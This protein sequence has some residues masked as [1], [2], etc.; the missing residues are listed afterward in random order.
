[1]QAIGRFV[2][3]AAHALTAA[4]TLAVLGSSAAV[5]AQTCPAVKVSCLQPA[6]LADA[7]GARFAWGAATGKTSK[8]AWVA[9]FERGA[10]TPTWRIPLGGSGDDAVATVTLSARGELLVAG[11]TTSPTLE[12]VAGRNSGGRDGF[13]VRLDA[14]SGRLLSGMFVGGSGDE[15]LSGVTADRKGNIL[16][17]GSGKPPALGLAPDTLLVVEPNSAA[18]PGTNAFLTTL[19]SGLVRM[20]SQYLL[21]PVRAK[22]PRVWLDCAGNVVVGVPA[23]GGGD[24]DCA[25]GWPDLVYEQDQI[26]QNYDIDHVWGGLNLG[27]PPGGWGYHAM[28]WK[29]YHANAN[30]AVG[31]SPYIL[32]WAL[33]PVS[34]EI[35]KDWNPVCGDDGVLNTLESYLFLQ[36]GVAHDPPGWWSCGNHADVAQLALFSAYLFHKWGTPVYTHLGHWDD[37]YTN[38]NEEWTWHT[39]P[40]ALERVT[41]RPFC[42]GDPNAYNGE[43]LD[44][45]CDIDVNNLNLVTCTTSAGIPGVEG[46]DFYLRFESFEGSIWGLILTWW[47]PFGYWQRDMD[48][49]WQEWYEPGQYLMD[50]P[51]DSAPEVAILQE[52]ARQSAGRIMRS[53]T[54]QVTRLNGGAT[55]CKQTVKADIP[56]SE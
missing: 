20:Q 39:N 8:D 49:W 43:T 19:D 18:G 50:P 40:V 23:L 56:A 46:D 25:G 22:H 3:G 21:G 38:P 54:V 51:A 37:L 14:G 34:P 7:G 53:G 2:S 31:E 5:S 48:Y 32:D 52:A 13:V 11:S 12:G 17:S 9:R 28:R 24:N 42:L 16:V 36:D 55:A 26:T 44:D 35:P 6:P 30:L 1:M 27:D 4:L 29:D 45:L 33:R 47:S 41:F 10:K 15:E